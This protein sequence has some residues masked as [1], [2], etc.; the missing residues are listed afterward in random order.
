MTA[1][2]IGALRDVV[3]FMAEDEVVPTDG[4]IWP[5][6][7]ILAQFLGQDISRFATRQEPLFGEE[8]DEKI[9]MLSDEDLG[10]LG[11][12]VALMVRGLLSEPR[13]GRRAA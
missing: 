2:Q 7:K 11:H 10:R 3:E 1:E 8:L 12:A 6:L 9:R 4:A 5:C 13:V